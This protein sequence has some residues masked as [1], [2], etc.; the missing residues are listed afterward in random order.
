VVVCHAS[1]LA[2]R[3]SARPRATAF[4]VLELFAFVH[5][6][7]I[8]L[9][10]PAGLAQALNLPAPAT[11]E[12][13]AQLLIEGAAKLLHVLSQYRTAEKEQARNLAMVLLRAGWRWARPVLDRLG[14]PERQVSAMAALEVWRKLPE[15]ED[16]P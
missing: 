6:A 13:A 15:W 11:P 10:G 5:P 2:R 14:E 12:L 3:L 7:E 16:E 8:C 9:P 4:D 1:W